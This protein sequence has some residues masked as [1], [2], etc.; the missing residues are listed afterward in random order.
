MTADGGAI[1]FVHCTGFH[2]SLEVRVDREHAS[3]VPDSP[4][5][6]NVLVHFGLNS[7]T[8]DVV[9]LVN[10]RLALV[11][12]ILEVSVQALCE[13]R[14]AGVSSR[15][16]NVSV[17]TDLIVSRAL[18]D[19]SVYFDFYGVLEVLVNELR[20]EEHLRAHEAFVAQLA[21]DHVSIKSL[22]SEILK[23]LCVLNHFLSHWVLNLLVVPAKLLHEVGADIAVFLFSFLS[24]FI[25]VT[26]RQVLSVLEFFLNV[27]SNVTT[28][29][30][31]LLHGGGDDC[32][33]T[34]R[35][36]VSDTISR[37]NHSSS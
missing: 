9:L 24:K 30:G 13:A 18:L 20:M 19:G 33:V 35:H 5:L 2:D 37:V 15:K 14:E 12:E 21:V 17:Q 26:S 16:N 23:P 36:D 7:L 29:Q 31:D 8:V 27:V 1:L 4:A 34:N 22:V 6:H 32:A 28:S 25:E 10:C 11:A 3:S